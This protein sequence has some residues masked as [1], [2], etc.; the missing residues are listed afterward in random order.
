MNTKTVSEKASWM[1]RPDRL[2][3]VTSIEA[4]EQWIF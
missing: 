1:P 2:C 3:A 4:G